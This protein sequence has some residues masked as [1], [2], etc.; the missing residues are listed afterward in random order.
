MLQELKT[1][2]MD[3]AKYQDMMAQNPQIQNSVAITT[4]L[5]QK[6]IAK[7]PATITDEAAEKYYR[8][9]QE[10]QFKQPENITV[11]HILCLASEHNM[12]T[13]EKLSEAE[14]KA[15]DEKARKKLDEVKEKLKKGQKF[16]DLAAQYSDCGSGKASKGQLPAFTP[17]GASMDGSQFESTF[18]KAAYSIEKVGDTKEVKTPFGYHII[19]LD[20]KTPEQYIEFAQVKN[21]IKNYLANEATVKN[22]E[23]ALDELK[24]VMKVV[25]HVKPAQEAVQPQAPA[26]K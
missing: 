23:K 18:T 13:G 21:D 3:F 10:K 26:A 2:N 5:Q 9:N 17:T 16:E 24:K 4:Y 7:D 20:K 14:F 19:R 1:Q 8:E 12:Q 11:S 25:V 22:V 15:V 6:N